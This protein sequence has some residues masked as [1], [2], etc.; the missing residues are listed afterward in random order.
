[1]DKKK[2][3]I[4]LLGKGQTGGQVIKEAK[5]QGFLRPLVFD[6][7]NAPNINDLKEVA[8]IVCFLPAPALKQYLSVLIDSKRPLISGTTGFSWPYELDQQLKENKTPWIWGSNFSLGM[9]L[10]QQLV[11]LFGKAPQIFS[12]YSAKIKETHHIKKLDAPSGT[13]I[14]WQEWSGLNC[15]IESIRRGDVVG[16][17]NF[18]LNTEYEQVELTHRAVSREVFAS[19]A[20]WGMMQ[21]F[22]RPPGLHRFED[23][24]KGKFP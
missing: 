15:E 11:G 5:K 24:V 23:V 6:R 18:F 1:M 2:L 7:S 13:A 22:E 10:M 9:V 14:K 21:L 20:L 16:E 17:H 8:A 19:G 4:A 3:K 12:N